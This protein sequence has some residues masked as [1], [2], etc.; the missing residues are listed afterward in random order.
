MAP[1][2]FGDFAAITSTFDAQYFLRK[3][4]LVSQVA[5]WVSLGNGVTERMVYSVA[6]EP[7]LGLANVTDDA[8]A[9]LAQ[10]VKT[11]EEDYNVQVVIR[12]GH[13]MDGDWYLWGRK[14]VDYKASYRR[15][16]KAIRAASPNTLLLWSP[17]STNCTWYG[18][19]KTTVDPW[20]AYY[21]G[22]D[23]VDL[24]GL[25]L[26]FFGR[27]WPKPGNELPEWND[28]QRWVSGEVENGNPKCDF[29]SEFAVKRGKPF[30]VSE[31][32]AAFRVN[33][34]KPSSS[35]ARS[36]LTATST[37]PR[38]LATLISRM[39]SNKHKRQSPNTVS[40]MDM[41]SI[42]WRQIY[43]PETLARYP[44][45]WGVVWF[46]HLKFELGEW[47]DF[48][49]VSHG[50]LLAESEGDYWTEEKVES[51]G[52]SD[53]AETF[54]REVLSWDALVFGAP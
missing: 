37:T 47:R 32:A 8:I 21:P 30:V 38:P 25:S 26:Y 41:K 17:S 52:K 1:S 19:N 29:Y 34:P 45:L 14:P 40:E 4:K 42:W 54:R 48:R 13:E 43:N 15:V 7:I 20:S 35:T 28:F 53:L 12:Y 23:V 31:T 2:V 44:K 39:Q 18:P 49:S 33:L 50:P 24:V 11:A 16:A 51:L 6:V 10:A 9:Q 46:E 5:P 27:N 3:A 22:D 36:T